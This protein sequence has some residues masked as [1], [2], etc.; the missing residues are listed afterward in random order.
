MEELTKNE[1]LKIEAEKVLDLHCDSVYAWTRNRK[2]AVLKAMIAYGENLSD[3]KAKIPCDCKYGIKAKNN[4]VC[5]L[6]GG[7][8]K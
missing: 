4:N 6:C 5:A 1:L 7:K 2:E 3:I 8:W